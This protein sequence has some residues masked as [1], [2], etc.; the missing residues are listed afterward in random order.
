MGGRPSDPQD[1]QHRPRRPHPPPSSSASTR[2]RRASGTSSTRCVRV[3]RGRQDG[4]GRPHPTGDKEGWPVR[5]PEGLHPG[6]RPRLGAV[7]M[8]TCSPGI[9]WDRSRLVDSSVGGGPG[10]PAPRWCDD[11]GG[12]ARVGRVRREVERAPRLRSS[13]R[14]LPPAVG[15]GLC[16]APPH[17]GAPTQSAQP[18]TP[19]GSQRADRKRRAAGGAADSGLECC[20]ALCVGVAG[21][22]TVRVAWCLAELGRLGVRRCRLGAGRRGRG[23]R[24]R[25]ARG[26][27]RLP[28]RAAR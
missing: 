28:W 4:R 8:W 23:G 27:H 15:A 5:E 13:G 20:L 6:W 9:C 19:G 17:A 16:H 25:A 22:P 1:G 12:A 7:A 3:W 18:E 10:E 24:A 14:Q 26:C 11:A 21:L 2:A